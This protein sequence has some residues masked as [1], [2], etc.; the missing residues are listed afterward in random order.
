MT[1]KFFLPLL[2]LLIGGGWWGN[3]VLLGIIVGMVTK[4]AGG[5]RKG[6]SILAG[7]AIKLD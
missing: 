3:V 4:Y 1:L 6:F 5:D 2:W 7:K